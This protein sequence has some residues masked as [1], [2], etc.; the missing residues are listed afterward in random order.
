MQ[1]VN[2]QQMAGNGYIVISKLMFT[3]YMNSCDRHEGDVEAFIK[4]LLKVNYSET[5]Y[6]DYWHNKSVCKRGES[7]RSYRSWGDVFHWSAGKTYR[8]M[9]R[10]C[11]KGIIEIIPHKDAVI[12]HIRVVNY[13]NW[14]SI[15]QASPDDLKLQRKAAKEQFDFFWEEYHRITLLPKENI[16]KAQR[17]WKKLSCKEQQLA[18]DKIEEYYFHQTN[19]KYVLH[20]GSY[21]SNKAFL[22]E[23]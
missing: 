7:L 6:T 15:P 11:A 21:L 3:E 22:N 23:Y 12:L 8:F 5:E 18:I 14:V 4:L 9:Q 17:E 10:L 19:S 20:A 16:A 2:P 13:E 1:N